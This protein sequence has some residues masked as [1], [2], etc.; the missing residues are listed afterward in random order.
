MST[1]KFEPKI[2]SK[3]RVK[4]EVPEA[5]KQKNANRKPK[6]KPK[7]EE[8]EITASG[9]FALGPAARATATIGRP[10]I[11]SIQTYTK[12]DLDLVDTVDEIMDETIDLDEWDPTIIKPPSPQQRDPLMFF[13]FPQVFPKDE[14]RLVKRKSGKLEIIVGDLVF[15]INQ[16]TSKI[17]QYVCGLDKDEGTLSFYGHSNVR[18]STLAFRPR[19]LVGAVVVTTAAVTGTAYL[20]TKNEQV[21]KI[22]LDYVPQG[23]TILDYVDKV[24]SDLQKVDME[25][26]NSSATKTADQISSTYQQTVRQASDIKKQTGEYIDSAYKSSVDIANKAQ[27]GYNTTMQTI[28]DTSEKI[29]KT[30][31][32]T[33]NQVAETVDQGKKV[34]GDTV[35]VVTTTYK[36]GEDFVLGVVDSAEQTYDNVVGFVTGSKPA[37]RTPRVH[38][39]D[40]NVVQEKVAEVKE[41]VVQQ[42]REDSAPKIEKEIKTVAEP[43]VE[44]VAEAKAVIEKVKEA[45]KPEIKKEE[46]KPKEKKV[47]QKLEEKKE[48]KPVEAKATP[49]ETP[50]FEKEPIPVPVEAI[51]VLIPEQIQI[52]N[53]AAFQSLITQI[54][55]LAEHLHVVAQS[56]QNK[57][58]L[59]KTAAQLAGLGNYLSHLETEESATLARALHEQSQAFESTIA[60]IRSDYDQL[61]S[62]TS[63]RLT[64]SFASQMAEERVVGQESAAKELQTRLTEQQDLFHA[65]LD[66]ELKSQAEQLDAFWSLEIKRRLDTEREGRLARLDHLALKLKQLERIS[67][68]SSFHLNRSYLIQQEMASVRALK[69]K[70]DAPISTN[71]DDELNILRKQGKHDGLISTVLNSVESNT[72]VSKEELKNHFEKIKR[73]LY[74]AQLVPKDAGP[75]SYAIAALLSF[76]LV[77]KQGLVPGNTTDSILSRAQYYLDHDDIDSAAREIN[78]LNGWVKVLAGDW[79]DSAR[80]HLQ[81]VQAVE[82]VELKLKLASLGVMQ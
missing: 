44:K 6:P 81:T 70:L 9:P 4:Q 35:D 58:G 80:N 60:K 64:S 48:K 22:W 18:N 39:V 11:S 8:R 79:L 59:E 72:Y 27:D 13:T 41:Q 61:L 51:P 49:K 73:P 2:P 40:P 36:R 21:R 46:R 55:G 74:R 7:R 77:P 29:Q 43:V 69:A 42:L 25:T 3:R 56:S 12:T 30:V 75:L 47:E 82:L 78:Q 16:S 20:A 1:K 62:D 19:N 38:R 50:A 26:I 57:A 15:D 34:V 37:P 45:P 71:F 5:D 28:H 32:N 65:A 23:Q 31:G 54:T 76:T 10:E 63:A 66:K 33:K 24:S 53:E 68:D 67:L 14:A 17:P 52:P